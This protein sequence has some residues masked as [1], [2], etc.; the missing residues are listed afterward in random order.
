MSEA[1]QEKSEIAPERLVLRDDLDSVELQ[2]MTIEDAA[3]YFAL[4]DADRAHL[5]QFGDKTAYKYQT[6]EDVEKSVTNPDGEQHRFGIWDNDTMVGF[7]KLKFNDKGDWESG[8]WVGSQHI[9]NKY[10]AR[11]RRLLIGYAFQVLHAL[12]VVSTCSKSPPTLT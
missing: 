8:S 1:Q 5:S 2:Q 12:R 7:I 10:A 11:A 3:P 6:V 4:V 9:G